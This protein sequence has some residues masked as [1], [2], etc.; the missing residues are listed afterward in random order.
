MVT[1]RAQRS[2]EASWGEVGAL[3]DNFNNLGFAIIGIFAAAWFV[4]FAIYKAKKLDD[5]E[6]APA[7]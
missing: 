5:I 1:S 6:V 7:R 4:S 3:N 2:G